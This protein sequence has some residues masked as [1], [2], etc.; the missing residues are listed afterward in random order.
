MRAAQSDLVL[1][2]GMVQVTGN[3]YTP[4]ATESKKAV[5]FRNCCAQC[6]NDD[7]TVTPVTLTNVCETHG[8]FDKEGIIKGKEVDGEIVIVGS[9]EE[10]KEAKATT[11]EP[12]RID[13]VVH[14]ADEVDEAF[15]PGTGNTYV[16]LPKGNTEFYDIVMGLMDDSGRIAGADG[17]DRVIVGAL[18]VRDAEHLV[19]LSKW[20]GH[21]VIKS[22]LRPEQLNEFPDAEPKDLTDKQLELGRQLISLSTEEFNAE[23][24]QR[25]AQWLEARQAGV[26]VNPVPIAKKSSGGSLDDMLAAAVAAVASKAA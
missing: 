25:L 10:V 22:M 11:I 2:L 4:E 13:L 8:T 16:Y 14:V 19:R 17:V 20:N 21:L 7:G 23:N 9:T 1:A 3:L 18:R 12:K 6:H 26:T 24:R 5:A 15:F